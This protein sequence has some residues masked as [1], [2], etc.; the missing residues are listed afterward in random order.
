MASY[1]F[2]SPSDIEQLQKDMEAA[3]T[4]KAKETISGGTIPVQCPKC[5]EKFNAPHGISTCPSCGSQINLHLNF[6]F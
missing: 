2:G 3:I 6:D 1:D 5:K 4:Q